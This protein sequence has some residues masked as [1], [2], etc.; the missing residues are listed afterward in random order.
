MHMELEEAQQVGQRYK[1][2]LLEHREVRMHAGTSLSARR[3][4]CAIGLVLGSLRWRPWRASESDLVVLTSVFVH[5]RASFLMLWGLCC[6][7]GS[8]NARDG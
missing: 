5:A 7:T 4:M 6:G 8:L 1:E 2:Q 3:M